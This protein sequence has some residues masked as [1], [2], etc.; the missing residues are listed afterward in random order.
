MRHLSE[1]LQTKTA[2]EETPCFKLYFLI[3]VCSSYVLQK[4]GK[5]RLVFAF[6]RFLPCKFSRQNEECPHSTESRESLQSRKAGKNCGV[7]CNSNSFNS[8]F[9][10]YNVHE[11]PLCPT[12]FLVLEK[13]MK[14]FDTCFLNFLAKNSKA[15]AKNFLGTLFIYQFFSL[16]INRSSFVIFFLDFKISPLV[17][18]K[19]LD[20]KKLK[21]KY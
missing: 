9:D 20:S 1:T 6:W 8:G 17:E 15:Q 16:K 4:R 7:F 19:N 12:S 11:I 10:F 2:V 3:Y 18:L 5:P 14:N 13:P 21:A